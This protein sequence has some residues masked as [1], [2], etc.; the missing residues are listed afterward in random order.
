MRRGRGFGPLWTDFKQYARLHGTQVTKDRE[1]L[2]FLLQP[3]LKFQKSMDFSRATSNLY[4]KG[5]KAYDIFPKVQDE[6]GQMHKNI[7]SK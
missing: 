6:S 1:S 2:T 7:E 5:T 4:V 3:R